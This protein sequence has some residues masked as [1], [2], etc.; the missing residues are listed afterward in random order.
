M[1]ILFKRTVCT[2]N[3]VLPAV[4]ILARER[5]WQAPSQS[6]KSAY[7]YSP[8]VLLQSNIYH[9]NFMSREVSLLRILIFWFLFQKTL[10]E[11][12]KTPNIDNSYAQLVTLYYQ[13][14]EQSKGTGGS[15]LGTPEVWKAD[16]RLYR[17]SFLGTY[18]LWLYHSSS[19]FMQGFGYRWQ[20]QIACLHL[21]PKHNRV[22]WC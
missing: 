19:V 18:A 4:I 21:P 16:S 22:W 13:D 17:Q 12:K 7:A 5:T 14:D 15:L 9:T 8:F 10:K 6:N 20:W 11:R 3:T 1:G 2:Q